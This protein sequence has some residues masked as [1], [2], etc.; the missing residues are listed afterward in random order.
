MCL[1]SYQEDIRDKLNPVGIKMSYELVQTENPAPDYLQPIMN[2]AALTY[3]ESWTHIKKDC[4]SD[5][6]CIPELDL[7]AYRQVAL[8]MYVLYNYIYLNLLFFFIF[9]ANI[10]E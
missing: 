8:N 3:T 5:D 1:I 6:V 4:G 10:H 9:F 2:Q 7:Q